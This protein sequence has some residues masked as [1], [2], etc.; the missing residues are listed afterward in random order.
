MTVFLDYLK[1]LFIDSLPEE[2]FLKTIREKAWVQASLPDRTH[3]AFQYLPLRELYLN[4]Y[5]RTLSFIDEEKIAAYLYLETQKS[6]L[7]FVNGNYY[8][9]L[10]QL[11]DP[12]IVSSLPEAFSAYGQFLKNRFTKQ[13]AEENDP[14]ALLNTAL[15][16][17]GAF[18]YLPP[19]VK[20]ASPIQILHFY[21]GSAFPRLQ[22]FIGA[23]AEAHLISRTIS[24]SEAP[25]WASALV[26]IALEE[27]AFLHHTDLIDLPVENWHFGAVRASLKNNSHYQSCSFH[28]GAKSI[29]QDYKVALL[30]ENARAHLQGLNLLSGK[31]Q[32]HTHIL[33]Q[34]LAPHCHS[35]Q[36]FKKVLYDQSQSSFQGQIYVHQKAQKT[37]A[38]QIN[39]NLILGPGAIANSKPNLKIFADDVKASHGATVGQLDQQALFYL[40]TRGLNE[41]EAS[42]FLVR[43]FCQEAIDAIPY[44]SV[45]ASLNL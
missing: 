38:Y 21:T 39:N 40:R 13:L 14:F 31:N 9:S 42:R 33:M 4:S 8:P 36:S 1:D 41:E 23:G 37:A 7:V 3:E 25:F 10:S 44:P 17:P 22:F 15:H 27:G 34:H 12:L 20:L 18:I 28:R 30:G 16:A 24:L 6:Y 5:P 26:D 11:P 45:R 2:S 32:A 29:R 35:M 43:S 19:K